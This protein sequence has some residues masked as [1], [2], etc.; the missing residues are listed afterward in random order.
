MFMHEKKE[1]RFLGVCKVEKK[2]NYQITL[3]R[4]IREAL[5]VDKDCE[6]IFFQESDKIVIRKN[7]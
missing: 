3:D 4:R 5:C 2:R 1:P 6:V 7:G